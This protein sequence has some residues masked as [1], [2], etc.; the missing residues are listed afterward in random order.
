MR[1]R[2][3]H[4]G[5]VAVLADREVKGVGRDETNIRHVGAGFSRTARQRREQRFAGRTHVPADDHRARRELGDESTAN[6][7]GERV[8]QLV[9]INST[10]V[11][12]LEDVRN[13]MTR[14]VR[15]PS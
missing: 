9:G 6:R 15:A 12:T 11:V 3:H 5:V 1:G 10:N 7:F 2:D 8:V 4:A 13:E 14:H